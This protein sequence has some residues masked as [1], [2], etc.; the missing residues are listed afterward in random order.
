L[1]FS[2]FATIGQESIAKVYQP[3]A[4]WHLTK[5]NEQRMSHPLPFLLQF[6]GGAE[7]V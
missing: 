1:S 5:N 6:V 2:V 3:P 4:L 7:R